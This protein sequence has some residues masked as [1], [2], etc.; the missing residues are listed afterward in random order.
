MTHH[1]IKANQS[2]AR[3]LT[4]WTDGYDGQTHYSDVLKALAPAM[5]ILATTVVLMMAIL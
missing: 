1:N 4:T 2:A 3:S 5:L